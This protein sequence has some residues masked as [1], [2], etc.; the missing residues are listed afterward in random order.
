MSNTSR[1][2]RKKEQLN[3]KNKKTLITNAIISNLWYNDLYK[4]VFTNE[5]KTPYYSS[6]MNNIPL[7]QENYNNTVLIGE[8]SQH[9]IL[10]MINN[11]YKK[12]SEILNIIHTYQVNTSV[13]IITYS[14]ENKITFNM[15][16]NN[17]TIMTCD[18]STTDMMFYTKPEMRCKGQ[19][20]VN[21]KLFYTCIFKIASELDFFIKESNELSLTTKSSSV[22]KI[23][24][25]LGFI[26]KKITAY[27]D[28][29][30]TYLTRKIKRDKNK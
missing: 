17:S 30:I 20:T 12:A 28:L 2:N 18:F 1:K 10:D 3:N 29:D 6:I 16:I 15:I 9:L 7:T 23:S 24:K 4:K 27:K 8:M 5:T 21:L 14:L 13:K 19:I 26:E 22:I 11:D 25:D